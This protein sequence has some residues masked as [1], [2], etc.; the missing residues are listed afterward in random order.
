M[1]Q[2]SE[3][4]KETRIIEKAAAAWRNTFDH[5]RDYISILDNDY[6]IKRMNKAF[7]DLFDSSPQDLIGKTCF[8]LLHGTD[9]ICTHCPV[10]E[11]K[12]KKR[13]VV[14]EFYEPRLE[15][16]LEVTASPIFNDDGELTGC[17][18]ISKDI[19]EK[20]KAR[21]ALKKAQEELI[22]S[23]KMSAIGRLASGIAHEIRN[24]LANI[25]AS[26]QYCL[27]KSETSHEFIAEYLNII[28]KNADNAN[29]IIKDLL[30][31]ARP[32]KT[33]LIPGNLSEIL[34]YVH[35]SVKG[36]CDKQD[37]K[38]QDNIPD[39]IM[40]LMDSRQLEEAFLNFVSNSLDAMPDGGSLTIN[41]KT[42]SSQKMLRITIADT[43]CG[44]AHE[45]LNK[46]FEPFFTTKGNGVGLG[47]CM[48]HQVIMRHGGK[49][50]VES[51][52][53]KYTRFIAELPLF[54]EK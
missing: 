24:P 23:E 54:Q 14:S 50:A 9:E 3:S 7:A 19:S 44:I 2:Y 6:K 37:I 33:E 25:M 27:G 39:R 29:K 16:Y 1:A 46:I 30:D 42:L 17:I 47:L 38:W 45:N 49:L 13:S 31:F 26:A 20:I 21:E 10:P 35:D 51:E 40:I 53:G 11:M 34:G 12:E 41:T 8:T 4:K 52:A 43:G 22:E 32:R 15:M 28:M 18:H 5:I 48:A 36:R